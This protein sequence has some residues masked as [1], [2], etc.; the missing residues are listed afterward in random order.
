[1]GGKP[2]P[3]LVGMFVFTG[4]FMAI[5]VCF[6]QG[7]KEPKE[8]CMENCKERV[9]GFIVGCVDGR[10]DPAAVKFLSREYKVNTFER[11][12]WPGMVKILAE[13]STDREKVVMTSIV[14]AI[15]AV[16]KGHKP[17]ALII[18]AHEDCL[19][20]PV[21]NE[22]QIRQLREAYKL[23]DDLKLG[24]PIHLLFIL[25]G[26]NGNFTEHYDV[27]PKIEAESKAA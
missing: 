22:T 15:E 16:A 14:S 13:P 18:T 5:I 2:K 26:K 8:T 7:L 20:N 4:I 25:K 3:P 27:Q 12:L 1:M 9:H 17:V 23:I 24:V 21:D 19:G 11:F 6:V 10:P